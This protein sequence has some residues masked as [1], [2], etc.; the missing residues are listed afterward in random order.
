MFLS[1]EQRREFID[2]NTFEVDGWKLVDEQEL[3]MDSHGLMKVL[4]VIANAKNGGLKGFYYER[5]SEEYLFE[6][7]VEDPLVDLVAQPIST[8]EYLRMDG[9]EHEF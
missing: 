4:V 9:K 3:G 6:D 5:S 7:Y 8:I 2:D 1:E